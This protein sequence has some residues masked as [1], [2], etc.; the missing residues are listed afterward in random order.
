MERKKFIKIIGLGGVAMFT[1]TVL[2]RCSTSL[3]SSRS[4]WQHG[5]TVKEYNDIRLKILSFAILAPNPHNTQSWV[6]DLSQENKILLSINKEHLL[7]MT[8]PVHRQIYMGQGTFLELL[9]MTANEFGFLAKVNLFPLGVD[10]IKDVGNSP[11]A[12]VKLIKKNIPKDPLFKQIKNR[13]TNRKNYDN[14]KATGREIKSLL[15]SFDHKKF[16]IKFVHETKKRLIFNRLFTEAMKIETY[17][18]RTHKETVSML[19]FDN[20]EVVK[21]RDGFSYENL[22]ITGMSRFFA[23][24]FAGRDQAFSQSFKEKTVDTTKGQ[25]EST[26]TFGLLYSKGNSR[27]DQVEVGRAYVRINL[28]AT[29][30]GLEIHPVSQILQ[31][32]S[33]MDNLKKELLKEVDLGFNR[34][35]MIFRVGQASKTPHSP[36]RKLTSFIKR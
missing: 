16:P 10:S 1:P 19:R 36:R 13:I 29:Q 8:D 23:E 2:T 18:G 15:S 27:K 26:G 12:E 20:D 35:Q 6:V 21:Y 4:A 3:A 34:I 5:N 28:M 22:G 33:E 9:S 11:I 24:M 32:Y 30:I 31:E 7:P 25:V 17:T 14:R